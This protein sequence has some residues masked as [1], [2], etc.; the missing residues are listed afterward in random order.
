[1]LGGEAQ[2]LG[3]QL[4]P[5]G[6]ERRLDIVSD[7]HHTGATAVSH[8]SE[9]Q[10]RALVAAARRSARAFDLGPPARTRPLPARAIATIVAGVGAMLVIAMLLLD[11]DRDGPPSQAPLIALGLGALL[12]GL[13]APGPVYDLWKARRAPTVRGG[14]RVTL[15][16][17]EGT[18]LLAL[19]LHGSELRLETDGLAPP[20]ARIAE[21]RGPAWVIAEPRAAA[22]GPGLYRGSGAQRVRAIETEEYLSAERRLLRSLTL[23]ALSRVA[24]AALLA[25]LALLAALSP[26]MG[27]GRF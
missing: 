2:D 21:R 25:K 10:E 15:G 8:A 16:G 23:L 18:V 3:K 27:F 5:S 13:S 20:D 14:Q 11:R 4:C 6:V 19:D 7:A 24:A 17:N 22:D 1:M 26:G 12:L 9:S